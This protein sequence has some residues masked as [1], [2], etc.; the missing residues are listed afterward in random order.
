MP[1]VY[2]YATAVRNNPKLM[3]RKERKGRKNIIIYGNL[4]R[5]TNM[6]FDHILA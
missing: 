3:L 1:F 4:D 2:I 5:N 6:K